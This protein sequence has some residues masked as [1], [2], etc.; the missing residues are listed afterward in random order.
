MKLTVVATLPFAESEC[1]VRF[2]SRYGAGTVRWARSR[3]APLAE[4]YDVE[5]D[6]DPSK[7]SYRLEAAPTSSVLGFSTTDGDLALCADVEAVDDDGVA[8]L[9]VAVDFLM[10]VDLPALV[11]KTGCRMLLRAP[12]E[13]FKVTPFGCP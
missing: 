2:E 11:E 7:A 9:R 13:C 10:I 8:T 6:F 5:W 1:L 3:D 4:T 12:A